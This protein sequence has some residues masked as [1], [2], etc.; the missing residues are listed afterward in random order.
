MV[1]QVVAEV[2]LE[3]AAPLVLAL[4]VKGVRAV[5]AARAAVVSAAIRSASRPKGRPRCRTT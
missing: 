3:Q 1:S 4:A 5:E 2:S